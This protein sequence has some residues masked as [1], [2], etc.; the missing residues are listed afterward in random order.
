[1][2]KL[3]SC[4]DDSVCSEIVCFRRF[5]LTESLLRCVKRGKLASEQ[6]MAC[7]CLQLA[8]LQFATS[9]SDVAGMLSDA[10]AL[11]GELVDD[12]K[13]DED[14]R[15]ACVRALG[16]ALFVAG[17]SSAA[18][19]SDETGGVLGKL[20]HLFAQSYAKGDGTLRVLTTKQY[21][22][23]AA[24]LSTWCLLL[25]NMPL[26]FVN[27]LAQRYTFEPTPDA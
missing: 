20:E 25:C 9:T 17:A 15:A 13:L 3:V 10:R 6:I 4:Q 12:D 23:H 21:E 22:L 19:V 1:M 7:E 5:T 8:V 24:A 11:L 16:L 14:V 2:R 26:P 18:D 27:K